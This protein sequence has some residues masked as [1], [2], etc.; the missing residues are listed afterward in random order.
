VQPGDD[1]PV[2]RVLLDISNDTVKRMEEAL[3]NDHAPV[4]CV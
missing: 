4:T 1:I 3:T 2:P